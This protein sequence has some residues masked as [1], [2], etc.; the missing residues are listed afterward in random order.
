MRTKIKNILNDLSIKRPIFHSEADFQHALAWQ[1][2]E[3]YQQQKHDDLEIQLERRFDLKNGKQ[4]HLDILFKINNTKIFPF[5]L[6]YKT[7]GKYKKDF[8]TVE[9]EKDTFKLKN[10]GAKD[11]GRYLFLRDISRI[12]EIIKQN[13]F[14]T[15][16]AIFL[17]N[18]SGYW[19]KSNR[20]TI[21]KDFLIHEGRILKGVLKWKEGCFALK[22]KEYKSPINLQGTYKVNWINYS[23]VQQIEFKYLLLEITRK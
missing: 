2:K 14:D 11:G 23:N 17:T 13:K 9:T 21:D 8:L 19:N 1:I 12:E 7:K 10:Q 20:D 3:F 18:D 22:M 15:G 4:T 16:Y 6:K 5:E